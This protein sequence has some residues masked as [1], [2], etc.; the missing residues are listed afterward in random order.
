[1]NSFKKPVY[2][3]LKNFLN[4]NNNDDCLIQSPTPADD[5]DFKFQIT[6]PA[7]WATSTQIGHTKQCH[8]ATSSPRI[9]P[10]K[11]EKCIQAVFESNSVGRNKRQRMNDHVR[12]N[13]KRSTNFT[14]SLSSVRQFEFKKQNKKMNFNSNRSPN[15]IVIDDDEPE[16][17]SDIIDETID[18]ELAEKTIPDT[19]PDDDNSNEFEADF[20]KPKQEPLN[21]N[22]FIN[23]KSELKPKLELSNP[24]ILINIK[25]ELKQEPNPMIS[26]EF[27][28]KFCNDKI[29]ELNSDHSFELDSEQTKNLPECIVNYA[30]SLDYNRILIIQ[31]PN[32][33]RNFEANSN[34]KEFST[35]YKISFNSYLDETTTFCWQFYECKSCFNIVALKL[36]FSLN[37]QSNFYLL[38]KDKLLLID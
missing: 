4:R 24:N 7:P 29:C 9:T 8:G 27:K 35:C 19:D 33:K 38:F 32:S 3:T 15:V 25:P 2:S 10:I 31:D 16:S 14:S 36:R 17:S 1:M 22:V 11:T 26:F 18:S 30:Q 34:V 21:Q 12:S 37:T 5:S 23:L 6:Q 28:C 13:S 20:K